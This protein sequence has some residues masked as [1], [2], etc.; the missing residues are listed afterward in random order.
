LDV[1]RSTGMVEKDNKV[2]NFMGFLVYWDKCT[3]QV[4]KKI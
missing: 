3:T 1:V 4:E 2:K